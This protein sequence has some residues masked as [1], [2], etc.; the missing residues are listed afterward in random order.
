MSRIHTH[1][2]NFW[3]K[4]IETTKR[5]REHRIMQAISECLL[6][7]GRPYLVTALSQRDIDALSDEEFEVISLYQTTLTPE[8]EAL[9]KRMRLSRYGY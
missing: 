5:E 2:T 7:T 1:M 3:H 6:P 4:H 8:V 9:Y